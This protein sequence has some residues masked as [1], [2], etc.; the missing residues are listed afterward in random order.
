MRSSLY[1][2][3]FGILLFCS[4]SSS[5]FATVKPAAIFSD[6]MVLQQEKPV[7]VWGIASAGEKVTVSFAGQS[8]SVNASPSGSWRI[9][10]TPMPASA[11]SREMRISGNNEIRLND[12]LVGEVWFAGG[13]SNMEMPVGNKIRPNVYPGVDNFSEEVRNANYPM[14]RLFKVN[15]R[16]AV[17]PL[18]TVL[19]DGWNICTPE[20]AEVFSGVAYFFGRYLVQNLKI[21]VGIITSAAS[22][23]CVEQWTSIEALASLPQFAETADFYLNANINRLDREDRQRLDRWC[24]EAVNNPA[25]I[26]ADFFMEQTDIATWPTVTLPCQMNQL[27]EFRSFRGALWCVRDFEVP[28][29][30]VQNSLALKPGILCDTGT[31]WINGKQI[32]STSYHDRRSLSVPSGIIRAGRNRIAIRTVTASSPLAGITG[33]ANDIGIDVKDGTCIP[34]TGNWKYQIEKSFD[35]TALPA[36][37]SGYIA[38]NGQPSCLFNGGLAPIIPYTIR[39]AI[40]YQGESNASRAFEYSQLLPV[41][42]SD[43]RK[44]WSQGEFPFYQVQLAGK[45]DIPKVPGTDNWAELREA[46]RLTTGTVPNVGM[47]VIMDIGMADAIHPR[48]K[49]EVGRRLGLVAH[50]RTYGKDIEYSGPV[51]KSMEI[52]D[53]CAILCF[54]HAIGGPVSR[55]Q[56]QPGTLSSFAVAGE[57]RVWHW[58]DAVIDGDSVIVSCAMVA[59]PVAVRY[60]W[61]TNIICDFYNQTGLPAVPFRTD[62][63][64]LNTDGNL[65]Q[66]GKDFLKS[67][68]EIKDQGKYIR[69]K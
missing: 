24:M 49:Q 30:A 1:R 23:S 20:S 68:Q 45:G 62:T 31:V 38:P 3:L 56:K 26:R 29:N 4:L 25:L 39:G 10:L 54:D 52:R 37:P 67:W 43:W 44:R 19:S 60:G 11:E 14:L 40:W 51:F 17:R 13:Q 33:T 9:T 41:M 7:H 28:A 59:K 8:Q 36:K 58:A 35:V 15:R 18:D 46:Q 34:L 27:P 2:D 21:P 48:N 69:E 42:I 16:F 22:S 12:V 50:A 53:K 57:D 66:P 32:A 61:A 47:A 63:W 64:P 6:H 55:N 5:L 65:Y